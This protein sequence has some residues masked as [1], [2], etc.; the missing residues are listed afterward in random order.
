M[1]VLKVSE[2]CVIATLK[3]NKF[4]GLIRN[5]VH[6]QEIMIPLYKFIT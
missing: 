1:P 4:L 6:K 5:K 3:A 2:P